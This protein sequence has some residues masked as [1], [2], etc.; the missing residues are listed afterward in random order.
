MSFPIEKVKSTGNN[1]VWVCERGVSFGYSDL[2]VDATS[3]HRLKKLNVPVI[4][5]CTHSA[6]KPNT[7]EGITG[8]DPSLIET[9]ALHAAATGAD[10]LFMETHPDPNQAKSDPYTMLKLDQLRPILEKVIKIRGALHE[11]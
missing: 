7:T 10:G 3:I 1:Q 2:V 5:D 9:I 8:G 6:Q 11:G 4:M